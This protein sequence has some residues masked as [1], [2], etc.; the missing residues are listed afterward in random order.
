MGRISL[1][2]LGAEPHFAIGL[3]SGT[4]HDGV[5][6]ALVRFKGDHAENPTGRNPTRTA[7]V[8]NLK[9]PP[10]PVELIAFAT[11]PYPRQFRERLLKASA[12]VGVG[13]GELSQ[14][15]FALGRFLARAAVRTAYRGRIPLQK[16]SF[17]G[18]HGHTF[19]HL[20]PRA[21]ARGATPS[22]LQLGEAAV[23]AATTGLPVVADFRPMDV[24]L[25]GEGA[26][27]APLAHLWL[28]GDRARGRI[29]QNIGGIGNATYLPPSATIGDPRLIAFDTGPGAG[30]IDG[31]ASRLTNGRMRM[32]RD[33]RMAARG[34]VND[35]FL[36]E[37]SR[38]GYF[39]RRPPKSTGRE[40]FGAAYLE[41]V[42]TW[43]RQLKIGDDE[44]LATMTALTAH[45]IADACR[46]FIMP[47]GCV[48]E[49]IVTG[50]GAHNPTLMRM[51]KAELA[52]IEVTTANEIG[53][54]SSAIEAI[55]FA[56]LAYQ[57]LRNEPGNIPTVTGAR[58]PAILGK[59]TLPPIPS[60]SK[61]RKLESDLADDKVVVGHPRRK[62][63]GASRH[64]C[65]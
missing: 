5:S 61:G 6:A 38:N 45:S 64:H 1:Q 43:A 26:P 18:T 59:L 9:P 32:D 3:M 10:E 46:R 53:F 34:V 8:T 27:L 11:Y 12:G 19:H 55:A 7:R 37:L 48:D 28:L 51:L 57:F 33:G 41:H 36:R 22:T 14:L 31:L 50:G 4:S 63:R 17:I 40:E 35:A 44:L 24:A 39:R 20:P 2:L 58:G 65:G 54:E 42:E 62:K 52:E 60:A 15:N 56:I 13:G 21:A 30:L 16:L 25:G 23:I 29:V 49:L 47:L